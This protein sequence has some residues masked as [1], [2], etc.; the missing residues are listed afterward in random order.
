MVAGGL[1]GVD[2]E[3]RRDLLDTI[4]TAT[5]ELAALAGQIDEHAKARHI[6]VVSA[7]VDLDGVVAL[8]EIALDVEAMVELASSLGTQLMY[9]SSTQVDAKTL[10]TLSDDHT[11]SVEPDEGTVAL[12]AALRS[13]DGFTSGVELAFAY[14]GIIHTWTKR[15]IWADVLDAIQGYQRATRRG[16][17]DTG[18]L[19]FSSS[20][21]GE[22]VVAAHVDQLAADPAF[23]RARTVSERTAAARAFPAIAE[24]AAAEHSWDYRRIVQGAQQR[25]RELADHVADELSPRIAE[26]AAEFAT[27]EQFRAARL[28]DARRRAADEWISTTHTN[29]LRLPSWWIKELV[30]AANTGHRASGQL[31][32]H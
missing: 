13:L 15:S 10:I 31:G 24:L 6:R 12:Q 9:L 30:A 19:P 2:I 3:H 32:L 5:D 18:L 21:V 4:A 29:G 1:V 14:G 8:D 17:D 23:R 28:V 25:V 16:E 7:S 26:L 20:E 27:T 22:Q 11:H